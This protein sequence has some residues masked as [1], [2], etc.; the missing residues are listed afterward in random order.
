MVLYTG[1]KSCTWHVLVAMAWQLHARTI[2]SPS[3]RTV[4]SWRAGLHPGD[5][6]EDGPIH[7]PTENEPG[8]A[9]CIFCLWRWKSREPDDNA[10]RNR[11]TT[12]LVHILDC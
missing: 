9:Q 2:S 10:E 4:P 8:V 12:P 5:D 3:V 11:K 1:F 6:G 7:S